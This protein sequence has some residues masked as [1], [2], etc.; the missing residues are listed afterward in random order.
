MTFNKEN[1]DKILDA[2]FPLPENFGIIVDYEDTSQPE[3][4]DEIFE[5]IWDVDKEASVNFGASKLVIS[6]PNIENVV[7]K[8]P[9]N[10]YYQID[11][12]F[13]NLDWFPFEWA[14]GSDETDYCLTEYEKY[15]K[16]KERKLNCFVAKTFYYKTLYGVRIFLQ[17][18]VT[19]VADGWDNPNPSKNS[20]DIAKK[21][22]KEGKFYIDPEWIANCLD[23]YGKSKVE[24]FLYYCSNIDSEILEDVHSGN[25]GYRSNGTPALLDFSSYS[26]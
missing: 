21:W 5:A 6:S 1:I 24:K 12:I 8:I 7:I 26:G 16:L 9:F 15:K 14:S 10:G 13:G 18:K 22:Y 19:S 17:E 2:I 23:R 4:I 3:C 20:R 11:S 25:F